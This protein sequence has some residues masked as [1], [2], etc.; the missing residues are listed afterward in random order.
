MRRQWARNTFGLF[1]GLALWAIPT[2]ARAHA[3]NDDPNLLHVCI[4]NL[5][6]IVRS[7]GV[8]GS[9]IA[10]PSAVAETADHWSKAAIPGPKGD[11]G[12]T[13]DTG[14]P[15]PPGTNGLDGT[16]GT[17]A[18]GPCFD[19]ANRYVDCGNGTVSDTVTGLIWLKRANC[20][21]PTD[22][23]TANQ[24]TAGLK[25]GDCGLTDKSSPGD[26]RLPTR[27]EWMATIEMAGALRCGSGFAGRG[28]LSLTNDAGTACYGDGTSSSLVA[29]MFFH[30][31]SSSTDDVDPVRASV[32]HLGDGNVLNNLFKASSVAVWPVKGGAR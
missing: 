6:K 21:P 10:G 8:N 13:G 14:D 22:W 18:D 17:R 11:K 5:S 27:A 7:V 32:V 26:W 20:I 23:A 15:G 30:Y 12:D 19:N 29:V 3:G 24:A 16:G 31:W 2:I 1:V 9:C 28:P 25:E 4:G